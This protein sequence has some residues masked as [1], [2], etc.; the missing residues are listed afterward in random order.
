MFIWLFKVILKMYGSAPLSGKLT[1]TK[2]SFKLAPSAR[3]R[4][5]GGAAL[6]PPPPLFG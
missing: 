5:G 2:I 4:G 1:T 6:P 3:D